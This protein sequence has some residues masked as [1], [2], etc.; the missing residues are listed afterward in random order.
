MLRRLLLPSLFLFTGCASAPWVPTRSAD[1]P[2][3]TLVWVGVGEC[4]RYVDGQWV[5]APEFDYDFSV[6][7]RRFAD[8][9]QSVKSL[10]RRHPGYDGSAG[11][12]TNTWFFDLELGPAGTEQG[13]PLAVRSSLGNGPGRADREFREA[14]LELQANVSSMAPF[15]RYR[16][17]QHYRYEDGQLEETVSLDKGDQPWVRNRERASLFAAQAFSQ[18]PTHR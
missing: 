18:P 8:R 3:A 16:I 15:D 6:E 10:R 14:T 7:Q 1:A 5:R 11:P 4:E 17:E 9:W 2:Q 12:R 13:V